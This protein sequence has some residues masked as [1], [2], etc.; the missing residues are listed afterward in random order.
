MSWTLGHAT[1]GIIVAVAAAGVLVLASCA[2]H[3]PATPSASSS[4]ASKG[5]GTAAA[6]SAAITLDTSLGGTS[7]GVLLPGC[8]ALAWRNA[9]ISVAR[10][11][12]VPPVPVVTGIRAGTHPECRYDRL[13]FDLNGAMPGYQIR[14]VSSVTADPS[15]KAIIVPG[16]GTAYLLIVLH[17]AQGHNDAGSSTI[18][19]RSAS[20]GYPSLKGYTVTGDFEGYATVALGLS[21]AGQLRVGELSKRLYVDVSY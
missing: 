5:S 16:G 9:P 18:P 6:P 4:N 12:V 17:P 10:S 1:R 3:S 19:A 15:G 14:Y 21:H 2:T 11:P 8:D 20:L 7:G 13:T